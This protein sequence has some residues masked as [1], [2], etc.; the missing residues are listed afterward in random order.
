MVMKNHCNTVYSQ[1]DILW[2][3]SDWNPVVSGLLQILLDNFVICS[4]TWL[5]DS[6][7][8]EGLNCAS[9]KAAEKVGMGSSVG[10]YDV[11]PLSP[12]PVSPLSSS[13]K[14]PTKLVSFNNSVVREEGFWVS[15]WVVGI[16]EPWS[17]C[18][19][20]K[21]SQSDFDSCVKHQG[22]D[23]I[24]FLSTWGRRRC[25]CA[26]HGWWWPFPSWSSREATGFVWLETQLPEC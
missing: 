24:P 19:R 12:P 7:I 2:I 9:V 5:T 21:M 15:T 20:K 10:S 25:W 22:R 18:G 16:N 14:R 1:Q 13:P 8:C 26:W 11:S 6:P 3:P 17:G 23:M 4:F